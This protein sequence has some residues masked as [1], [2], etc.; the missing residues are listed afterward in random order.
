MHRVSMNEQT[1]H[2]PIFTKPSGLVSIVHSAY[3][4][5]MTGLNV[6]SNDGKSA[7]DYADIAHNKYMTDLLEEAGCR[8]SQ[9]DLVPKSRGEASSQVKHPPVWQKTDGTKGRTR[10]RPSS[11]SRR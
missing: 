10:G 8:P 3:P 9:K 1:I 2:M 11:L 4:C 5:T 6:L 7:W